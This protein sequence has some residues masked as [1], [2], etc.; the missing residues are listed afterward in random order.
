MRRSP[1]TLAVVDVLVLDAR[2]PQYYFSNSG[3]C[4]RP[5]EAHGR[6]LAA[7]ACGAATCNA[8]ARSASSSFVQNPLFMSSSQ[9]KLRRLLV[10]KEPDGLVV[11]TGTRVSTR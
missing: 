10:G 1:R 5:P 11:S 7:H 3:C 8:R 4:S 9:I 6:G 2:P